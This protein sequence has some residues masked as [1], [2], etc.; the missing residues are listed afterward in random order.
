LLPLSESD[1]GVVGVYSNFLTT[2]LNCTL[3]VYNDV[4]KGYASFFIEAL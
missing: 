1:Y 2:E 4:V 3:F